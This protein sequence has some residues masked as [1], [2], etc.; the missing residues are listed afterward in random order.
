MVMSFYA[1]LEL[2]LTQKVAEQYPGD[3]IRELKS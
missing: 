1:T 2:E 3:L